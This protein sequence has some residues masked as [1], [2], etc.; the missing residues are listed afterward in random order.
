MKDI[1]F[2]YPFLLW[3]LWLIPVYLYR[4]YYSFKK[5][6]VPYA[7]LQYKKSKNNRTYFLYAQYFLES[8]LL[9]C[10]I[11]GISDPHIVTERSLI[12]EDGL[13]I[14][15]V[16]D[17]SASMQA[18]DFEP[19]RLEAM[20]DIGKNFIKRSGGNRIGIFIFAQDTFTQTPL[21]TDHSTLQEL[22]DGI[23]FRVID[24]SES[25][26]TAIGDALLAA[27]DSLQKAKVVKR[28]QVIILITDGESSYGVDPILAAKYVKELG[29]KLYIIGLAG[30]EPIEVYAEG[31]PFL[32]PSGKI[33][34]TSLDDKQLKQI[35]RTADGKYYRAKNQNI[36]AD[37]F[38][39]LSN[40]SKTPL[41]IKQSKQKHSYSRYIA[42]AGMQIF[43]LW[44]LLDG[45]FV[46]RPMR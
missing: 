16:L 4:R 30:E 35:A 25:G 31:K 37:I 29:I 11:I 1:L 12:Q 26:G 21:T 23:S 14:A 3:F 22:L 44:I 13:D 10:I 18:A 24:H 8:I 40:L 5:S 34:V 32:T 36:L 6:S 38:S 33:L 39:E 15:L 27:T 45:L 2:T 42:F 41:E 46:R 7:P 43:F 17:V 20:K 9:S 19:N 28:D